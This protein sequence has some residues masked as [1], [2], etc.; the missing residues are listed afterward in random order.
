M[1]YLVAILFYLL[2]LIGVGAI[3]SGGV[4]TQDDF[5]VAGRSLT[6]PILVGTLIA[7]WIGTGSIFGSAGLG[8]Q[9]GVP[10]VWF[11]VGAWLGM[12]LLLFIAGRARAL[13]QYTVPDIFELRYNKLARLLGSLV[14]MVAYTGIVS[15]QLVA[16]GQ[17]L[18]IITG[19]NPQFGVVL[20]A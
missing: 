17:V 13:D 14:I 6:T 9:Y 4:N 5:M 3:R 18:N 19:L 16:G 15:Y 12:F 20:T 8:Y 2:I 11:S 7:T 10:G 1:I